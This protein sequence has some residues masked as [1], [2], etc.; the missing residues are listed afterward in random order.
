MSKIAWTD[1]SIGGAALGLYGCSH[2][3]EG[4][5]NC[6]AEAMAQRFEHL[7]GYPPGVVENGRWTGRVD[8]NLTTMLSR[9]DHLPSPRS[10]VR[11][12]FLW[13]TADLFHHDVSLVYQATALRHLAARDH[14]Q[15]QVL[16]KRTD[17]AEAV[18][19][20]LGMWPSNVWI[21][22]SCSTQA[23]V[24]RLA[25]DLLRVPAP[26][27]FLSMEPLL[28]P[29]DLR[30]YLSQ[31]QWVII[32]AES[33]PRRRPCRIE[34]VREVVEQCRES[35]VP[36]FVKQI[37]GPYSGPS[38]IPDVWHGWVAIPHSMQCQAD[39]WPADLRVRQFPE[40]DR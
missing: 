15:F 32:G 4:C 37:H 29:V 20:H 34:W 21:G 7:H 30:G 38:D 2:A 9:L 25:P 17:R 19:R 39:Q 22:A 12:V 36:C 35:G 26:V 16:T 8:E 28:G 10:S 31:I 5:R 13:S 23:D 3:G 1:M 27:R 6:W 33:G 14:L 40:E 11:R 24:D 18:G